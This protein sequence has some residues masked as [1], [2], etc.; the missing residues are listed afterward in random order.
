MAR[1]AGN[2]EMPW[3]RCD[4]GLVMMRSR[5]TDAK[6]EDS[7]HRDSVV[8]ED[9][10]DI[11]RGEFICRVTDEETCLSNGTIADDYAPR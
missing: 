7:H 4:R 2:G 1:Y 6:R 10:R 9:G 11:F 3:S 5:E 8:I